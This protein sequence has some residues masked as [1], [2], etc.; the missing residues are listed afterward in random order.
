[1]SLSIL[2]ETI[3]EFKGLI[4]EP[5]IN[6]S[7]YYHSEKNDAESDPKSDQVVATHTSDQNERKVTDTDTTNTN[8]LY[9]LLINRLIPEIIPV[10]IPPINQT[11]VD[12][13]A[14]SGGTLHE[15]RTILSKENVTG[16][17]CSAARVFKDPPVVNW[18]ET[19]RTIPRDGNTVRMTH[20]LTTPVR[21]GAVP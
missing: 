5:T 18:K 20:I 15:V 17:A 13:V 2:A 7:A 1:M 12:G 14:A 10:A 16:S 4:L 3:K 11:T 21:I 19:Y 6:D 8:Y 9:T